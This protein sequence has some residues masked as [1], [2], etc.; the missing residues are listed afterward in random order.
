MDANPR[1]FIE[2]G[3]ALGP[4]FK[5][6]E[7]GGYADRSATD[8]PTHIRVFSRPFAVQLHSQS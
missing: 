1:E 2:E 4:S 8:L 5:V 7:E 6:T 3:K